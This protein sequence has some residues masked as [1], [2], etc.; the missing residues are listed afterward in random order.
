MFF[1]RGIT[2]Q[3]FEKKNIGLAGLFFLLPVILSLIL[4]L[5]VGIPFLPMV[6]L[7]GIL[8]GLIYWISA[9]IILFILLRAFK[10]SS[11]GG[12][13]AN[14]MASFSVI[15]LVQAV[16]SIIFFTTLIVAIPSITTLSNTN[17]LVGLSGE[18]LLEVVSTIALPEGIGLTL[19]LI[20]L[21]VIIVS[22]LIAI[23]D[24]IYT[25]AQSV[26][27]TGIFS[28]LVFLAVFVV[29]LFFANLIIDFI[30]SLI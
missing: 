8:N 18:E 10:G 28:N 16:A 30:S 5:I 7:I 27:K 24:V 19:L 9:A 26:R 6:I 23:L 17:N 11:V 3:L 2:K 29:L 4:Q 22:T 12:K 20:T 13:F 1:V 25:I 21:V 14:I 15:Y